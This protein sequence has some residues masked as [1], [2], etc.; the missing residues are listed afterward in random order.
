M[1]F[2][3]LMLIVAAVI[4]AA[5]SFARPQWSLY[6]IAGLLP[7]YLI[8][9]SVF[10]LP[11]TWL[12]AMVIILAA[13][14]LLK[15]EVNFKKIRNDY[16]FWP[17]IGIL[18]SA[19]I[20][21]IV[22]PDKFHALGLWKAYF[23]EPIIYY[24][25]MLSL[26]KWHRELEG[27]FW[28]LGFSV[29]YLSATAIWQK[30]FAVGVPSAYMIGGQVDRVVSFFGYPNALGLLLGPI[31]VAFMGFL[32]FKNPDS[33]LLYLDN[34]QRFWLKLII[35][36]LG[37]A[38]II[39]AQSEGAVLAVIV[40]GWLMLFLNKKGRSYALILLALGVILF[41]AVSG[42]HDFLVSKLFLLDYSGQ[43]RRLIWSETFTM[44]KDHWFFGAGLAGYQLAIAPYHVNTWMEIFLYPHNILLNFWSELGLIGVAAFAWLI[45]K[46]F[47]QNLKNIFTIVCNYS[48]QLPF[49]KIV[50]FALIFVGLEIIIHGLVDVPY[51]KND[52]SVLFWLIIG[53]SSIN[54]K[55]KK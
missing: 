49:D 36:I 1:I 35:I 50:S 16:F 13:V 46:Y 29:I 27:I 51:F 54:A 3:Y 21:V 8:R 6:L 40:C 12:E 9:F 38:T 55:L 2:Y 28:A 17:I 26:L 14:V 25:L 41:F 45:V 7:T 52:L 44:L 5:L 19:T 47:W 42:L 15:K 33:L 24:W 10:G 31:L 18:I 34:A 11:L 43:V 30:I 37:L 20:A 32:F 48:Q 4:F 23:I 39:M 53:V 22:S